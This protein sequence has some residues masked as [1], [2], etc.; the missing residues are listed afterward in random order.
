M[1]D[2]R[3]FE[4]HATSV[5]TSSGLEVRPASSTTVCFDLRALRKRVQAGAIAITRR[6][7][8]LPLTILSGAAITTAPV[9]GN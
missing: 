2:D 8:P 3:Q 6:G 4:C 9:G 5:L 1:E 7:L